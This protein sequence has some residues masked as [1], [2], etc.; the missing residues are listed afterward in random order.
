MDTMCRQMSP[1]EAY[2][3]LYAELQLELNL[4]ETSDKHL[5]RNTLFFKVENCV[6]EKCH[7]HRK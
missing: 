5:L 4:E 1:Y 2:S 7:H 3:I 6:F